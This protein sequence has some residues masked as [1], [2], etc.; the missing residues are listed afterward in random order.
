MLKNALC[1]LLC[2]INPLE[3]YAKTIRQIEADESKVVGI[4]TALG[5]STIVEFTSKPISA[6]L[7]DQDAFKLEYVG[8]SITVKPLVAHARSNLFVFTEYDRFNCTLLTGNPAEVDYIVKVTAPHPSYPV[9]AVGQVRN[10][11]G[12]AAPTIHSK[13]VN[14]AA[15]FGGFV[16]KIASV[17]HVPGGAQG[18]AV[19]IIEVELSSKHDA[20]Q[21]SGASV[22]VRQARQ[23]LNIESLY[24]DALEIG[25][26]NQAV[27]GKIVLLDQDIRKSMP[28][29]VVF[30]VPAKK[31]TK[32]R[33][34]TT[35]RL[36]VTLGSTASDKSTKSGGK[37]N[38]K[39]K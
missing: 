35:H 7:G 30:A 17:A 3:S 14:K 25:P 2:F 24:L 19:T 10:D 21:F 29:A 31:S 37:P 6:V 4:H 16:L 8:N 34:G 13:A 28:L 15:A 5:Y 32:N 9:Q 33:K 26:R 1:I 11:E 39:G 23:F 12:P 20:Y 36:E 18:R 27:H 22:G 38:D